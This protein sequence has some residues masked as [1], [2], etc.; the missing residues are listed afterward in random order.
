MWKKRIIILLI[1]KKHFSLFSQSATTIKLSNTF[2][3]QLI[4]SLCPKVHDFKVISSYDE[5]KCVFIALK[6]HEFSSAIEPPCSCGLVTKADGFQ[7]T[8][9]AGSPGKNK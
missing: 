2:Y 5:G 4:G 6:L 8:T 7:M 1:T 3:L 9:E